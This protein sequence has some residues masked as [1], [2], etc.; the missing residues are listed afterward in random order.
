MA[1]T[2]E[3]AVKLAAKVFATRGKGK[4]VEVHLSREELEAILLVCAEL[5]VQLR[6]EPQ[7]VTRLGS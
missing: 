6:P 4:N 7:A 3:V 1:T 5:T 2:K